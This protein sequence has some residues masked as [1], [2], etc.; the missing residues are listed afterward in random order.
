MIATDK[1]GTLTM[2]EMSVTNILWGNDGE[3]LIPNSMKTKEINH[4][5]TMKDLL[6]GACLC[7]NATKPSSSSNGTENAALEMT[8]ENLPLPTNKV[9]G[10]AVDVALYH[11]CENEFS[12]NVEQMK[13]NN[14]RIDLIPFNSK[15]KFMIT[16]NLLEENN[17]TVLITLKGA[18]D[19]LLSRCSTYRSNENEQIFPIT[20]QF[21]HSIQQRQEFLGKSGYRVI[22]MLQQK[23]NK[24]QYDYSMNIFKKNKTEQQQQQSDLNR[25]PANNYSFIGK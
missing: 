10:D 8:N 12:I 14:P 22:A 17:E 21:K 15:N 19:F 5:S 1:T 18:P 4:S 7:N 2:N 20:D 23:I 11:L 16:A 13:K 24:S 3:Y 25:F 6:L 9:V